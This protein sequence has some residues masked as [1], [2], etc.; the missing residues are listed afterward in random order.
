MVLDCIKKAEDGNGYIVRLYE[1]CGGGGKVTVRFAKGIKQVFACD[2]MENDEGSVPVADNGFA[3]ETAP[4][5]IHSFRI[6][7]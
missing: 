3:F 1:A 4:Y 7:D 6:I 5:C 2:L